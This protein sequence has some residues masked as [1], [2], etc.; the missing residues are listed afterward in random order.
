MKY[1]HKYGTRSNEIRRARKELYFRLILV[2]AVIL[3][4]VLMVVVTRFGPR[5][6]EEAAVA[7]P[8]PEMDGESLNDP[9]VMRSKSDVES[10]LRTYT[11]SLEEKPADLEDLQ[12]LEEAIE[13]QRSVIRHRGSDIASREDLDRLEELLTLYDEEMGGFL[14]A[15]SN[16]LEAESEKALEE[17]DFDRAIKL[18]DGALTLQVEINEQYPRSSARS[19]S[20]VHQLKNTMTSLET[21]PLADRADRLKSE[22]YQ[23]VEAGQYEEAKVVIQ[24]ALEQQQVLNQRYRNSRL[25]SLSR[26]KQFEDA[27]RKIQ[28]AEDTDR[29]KR[30]M[31]EARSA[32]EAGDQATAMAQSESAAILQR[33]IAA[34]FPEQESENLEVLQAINR[35]RDSAASL[36]IY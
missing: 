14:I 21:R 17:K 20:R 32:L 26:L 31:E 28:N 25:A 36:S 18:I 7:Q 23:L 35:L 29:V 2:L 4:F 22:A 30:L 1:L 11:D 3:F 16:R 13:K 6:D 15:Q 19:A 33:R 24:Q 34:R 9:Q 8:S 5:L 12:L 10:L 27:W